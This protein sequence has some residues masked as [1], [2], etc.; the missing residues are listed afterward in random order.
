METAL[1]KFKNGKTILISATEI[2]KGLINVEDITD[3]RC[4]ECGALATLVRSD[5]RTWHFRAQ[6]KAGCSIPAEGA[7]VVKLTKDTLVNFGDILNHNDADHAPPQKISGPEAGVKGETEDDE[8]GEEPYDS[9][10]EEKIRYIRSL[11]RLLPYITTIPD[12][13]DLGEG[14]TAGSIKYGRRDSYRAKRY[15]LVGIKIIIA[16]RATTKGLKYS[17]RIPDG[18]V[19]LM[20]AFSKSKEDS[21]FF[22]VRCKSKYQNE[23]LQ[24]KV[25]IREPKRDGTETV[26]KYFYII[27]NWERDR[28]ISSHYHIYRA[29][30]CSRSYCVKGSLLW[31]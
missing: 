20:D 18:Y 23:I 7:H 11:N 24:E 16:K 19:L 25:T 21:C 1:A 9:I 13:F 22:L 15:G 28:Q 10:E 29:I 5:D 2:Y 27:A 30:I 26:D 31:E 12:D 17:F 14:L 4:P 8:N 6:H 3:L